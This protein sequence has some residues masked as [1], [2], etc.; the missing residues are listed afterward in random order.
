MGLDQVPTKIVFSTTEGNESGQIERLT[1]KPDGKVGIGIATPSAKLNILESS[2]KNILHIDAGITHGLSFGTNNSMSY[3]WWIQ[4]RDN[5]GALTY[6]LAL[7]PVGGSVGIGTYTPSYPLHVV[8]SV[9]DVSIYAEKNVSATGYITRTSTY[10][11]SKGK[12]LDK[13]K[14]A[15]TYKNADGTIK[16]DEFYGAV[17]YD[18]EKADLSRP[19]TEIIESEVLDKDNKI[20]IIKNE[21]ITYPYKIN[22]TEEGVSLDMEIDML[23]QA[24]YE[25]KQC[26]AES[27][28]WEKYQQCIAGV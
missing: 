22:V 24:V 11:K 5:N 20:K 2:N 10:D 27:K 25:I 14:D 21:K 13:V 15:D 4:S 1:I 16:H 12:A 28:D 9:G 8:G 6:P 17:S 26:T 19:V 23:R 3:A 18:V 7:N